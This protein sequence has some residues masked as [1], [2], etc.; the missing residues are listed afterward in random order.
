MNIGIIG[1]G[2][3]GGGLGTL[4]AGAGHG[5]VF[6]YTR[7]PAKLEALAASFEGM[8]TGIASLLP[9]SGAEQIA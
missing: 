6:S 1:S 7:D 4:W 3:T 2:N 5:V 9:V 8:T